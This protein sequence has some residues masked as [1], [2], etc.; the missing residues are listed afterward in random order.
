MDSET[1]SQRERR[2]LE[3]VSM[4]SNQQISVL[5][6]DDEYRLTSDLKVATVTRAEDVSEPQQGRSL[7]GALIGE[8]GDK[9]SLHISKDLEVLITEDEVKIDEELV[10]AVITDYVNVW[11]GGGENRSASAFI[12][13]Y[14]RELAKNNVRFLIYSGYGSRSAEA[15]QAIPS[16]KQRLGD[17]LFVGWFCKGITNDVTR[18]V[19]YM[20]SCL[21]GKPKLPPPSIEEV[22]EDISTLKHRI[23]HLFL[24]LDM[25]LQ[26]FKENGFSSAD[27]EAIAKADVDYCDRLEQCRGFLYGLTPSVLIILAKRLGDEEKA[28]QRMQEGGFFDLI[29][30]EPNAEAD[31][32]KLFRALNDRDCETAKEICRC[33]DFHDWFRKLDDAVHCLREGLTESDLS[34][35][36]SK[37]WSRP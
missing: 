7:I 24:S 32:E 13:A 29:D 27:W 20:R 33:F 14:S 6:V 37:A 2:N 35:N 25:N 26:I 11:P 17:D 18:I 34:Y 10:Q 19:L 3:V 15:C 4:D 28:C 8:L 5:V 22:L 23:A 16:I 36:R 12:N 1:V 30:K 21:E 31:V 9:I